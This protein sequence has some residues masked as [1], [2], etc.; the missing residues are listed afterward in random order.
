MNEFERRLALGEEFENQIAYRLLM[1]LYP[2]WGIEDCHNHQM[3]NQNGGGPRIR[4]TTAEYILPDYRLTNPK[5]KEIILVDAK[6]K[7]NPI[8]YTLYGRRVPCHSL[9]RQKFLHYQETANF[10]GADLFLLVGDEK[11]GK[12]YFY[13]HKNDLDDWQYFSMR[14][15]NNPK[16]LCPIFEAKDSRC[17]AA[18]Y[19]INNSLQFKLI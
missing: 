2:D 16:E 4:T 3:T 7:S 11:L 12:I 9:D 13:N 10:V 17:I 6:R 15:K 8:N 1:E 19:Q 18:L 5:T 14:G